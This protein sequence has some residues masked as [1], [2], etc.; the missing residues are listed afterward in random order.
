M[1]IVAAAPT[2]FAAIAVAC[3]WFPEEKAT[4]PARSAASGSP[5]IRFAAP[6]ILNA[7]PRCRFSH[8]KNTRV[9]ARASNPAEVITGVRRASG[10]I[11]P[12]AARTSS[13]VIARS[14]ASS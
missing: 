5:R 11:R 12:A 4:T 14:I 10:A 2:C 3:A 6:R 9:P 13:G 7:P 1:T 8:L